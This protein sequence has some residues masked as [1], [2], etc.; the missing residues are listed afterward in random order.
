MNMM[1]MFSVFSFQFSAF[2]R[3][4]LFFLTPQSF[5]LQA[6]SSSTRGFTSASEERR[7]S[8]ISWRPSAAEAKALR[9]FTLI[10]TLVAISILLISLAGPLS[11]AADALQSAYYARAEVTAY[12]LAQEGIEYVRAFRDQNYLAGST[13]SAWLAGIDESSPSERDCF[14]ANCTIDIPNFTHAICQGNCNQ[15]YISAIG[16]LYNQV[17]TGT[18]SGYIRSMRLSR[19]AG[20]NDEVKISVT[21][22]WAAAGIQRSFLLSENIFN[23]I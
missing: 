12:Y 8:L 14:S 9:A 6:S 19:T 7:E 18:P 13:G 10:E 1:E 23:W 17:Q 5:K 20:T 22:S 3:K 16:G 11:I 15:L 21:V 2:R 4:V